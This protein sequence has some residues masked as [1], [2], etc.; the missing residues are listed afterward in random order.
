MA[1]ANDRV[2]EIEELFEQNDTDGN[3]D[4]DFGEFK[5]LMTELDPQ[6]SRAALEIGFRD[7]DTNKDGR[8]NFDE[9]L[10]WWLA[11]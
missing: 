10:V 6:M 1:D 3:G 11:D 5:T 8:I 4:I 7:I 2:E 9:L